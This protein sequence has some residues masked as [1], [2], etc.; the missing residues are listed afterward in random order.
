MS[1]RG[2][3]TT[4]EGGREF[5]ITTDGQD[6]AGEAETGHTQAR[7]HEVRAGDLQTGLGRP[8]RH[9]SLS[10]VEEAGGRGAVATTED[11]V[12]FDTGVVPDTATAGLN[13]RR[14]IETVSGDLE[15]DVVVGL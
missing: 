14:V 11:G 4:G 12:E 13:L 10:Q 9:L 8:S 1:G 3:R 2:H 6:V 7:V 5:W 15:T